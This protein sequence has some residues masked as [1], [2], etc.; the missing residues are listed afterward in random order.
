MRSVLSFLRT[1]CDSQRAN[2]SQTLLKSERHHFYTT[3]PLMWDKLSWKMLLLVKPEMLGLFVNTLAA[4]TSILVTIGR[5]SRNKFKWYYL[6]NQNHFLH[7]SL[8]FWNLPQTLS[9]LKKKGESHSS[10]I[11]QI[12]DPKRGGYLNA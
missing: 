12:I 10:S 9:I 11:S 3:V 8:P 4:N 6:K 5:N 2:G 1:P 7:F